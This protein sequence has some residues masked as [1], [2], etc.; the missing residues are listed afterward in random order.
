VAAGAGADVAA[1]AAAGALVA[2]G[3]VDWHALRMPNEAMP[4]SP[5]E[6]IRKRRRETP[7]LLLKRPSMLVLLCSRT[8]GRS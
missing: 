1:L 6:R 5:A 4:I 3:G 2:A 8:W 7:L